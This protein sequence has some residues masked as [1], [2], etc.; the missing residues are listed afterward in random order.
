LA[1]DLGG[2]DNLGVGQLQLIRRC[3][4]LCTQCE[5]WEQ[6]AAEGGPFDPLMYSMLTNTLTRALKALGLTMKQLEAHQGQTIVISSALPDLPLPDDDPSNPNHHP[7][8][9]GARKGASG[10]APP[11]PGATVLRMPGKGPT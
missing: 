11:A 5:I 7:P 8:P 2:F 4:M 3:A 1:G 10:P 6:K 9:K